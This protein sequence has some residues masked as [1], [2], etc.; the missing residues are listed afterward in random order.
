MPALETMVSMINAA[1]LMPRLCQ[2]LD[3]RIDVAGVLLGGVF[4]AINAAIGIGATARLLRS[5]GYLRVQYLPWK[6]RK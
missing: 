4:I 2:R 3:G 5:P 6:S 1:G